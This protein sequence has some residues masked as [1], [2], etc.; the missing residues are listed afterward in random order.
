MSGKSKPQLVTCHWSLATA[1]DLNSA[2]SKRQFS[3]VSYQFSV[4][5]NEIPDFRVNRRYSTQSEGAAACHSSLVT[6]FVCWAEIMVKPN[7]RLGPVS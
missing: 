3:V 2:A 5:M 7:G 6:A 4:K 1:R